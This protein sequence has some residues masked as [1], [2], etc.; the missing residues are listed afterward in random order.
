MAWSCKTKSTEAKIIPLLFSIKIPTSLTC[1]QITEGHWRSRLFCLGTVLRFRCRECVWGI[2]PRAMDT[3]ME[4]S[5]R[6]VGISISVNINILT[7]GSRNVTLNSSTGPRLLLLFLT[8]WSKIPRLFSESERPLKLTTV[9]KI[10][11]WIMPVTTIRSRKGKVP[12]LPTRIVFYSSFSAIPIDYRHEY[13]RF[14]VS[15]SCVTYSF[16]RWFAFQQLNN[17]G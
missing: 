6:I 11:T 8:I 5:Y 9:K 1:S 4:E 2:G 13:G 12:H 16:T 3:T 10:A 7:L 17:R 14:P 15:K